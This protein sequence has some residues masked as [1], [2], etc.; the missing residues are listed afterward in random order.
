MLT[1]EDRFGYLQAIYEVNRE[2]AEAIMITVGCAV[3]RTLG[4]LH[5]AG[6]HCWGRRIKILNIDSHKRLI[7]IIRSYF[8]YQ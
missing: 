2:V 8:I 3:G 6:G 7:I 5:G 1:T 4:A